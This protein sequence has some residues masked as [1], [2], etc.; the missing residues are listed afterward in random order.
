MNTSIMNTVRTDLYAR[1]AH[2]VGTDTI[3]SILETTHAE[4]ARTAIIDEFLPVL[5]ERDVAARLEELGA[6]ATRR[7]VFVHRGNRV[8]ADGAAAIAAKLSG[9]MVVATA[10]AAHPEN[11]TD[12]RMD[13]VFAERGYLLPGQPTF[14]R[15]ERTLDAA[16]VVVYL[17][18]HENQNVAA[19]RS[20][21]WNAPNTEGFSWD[22]A[23]E[24]ADD[25]EARVYGLLRALNVPITATGH[26]NVF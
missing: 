15:S 2:A 7:V 25:I 10:T 19:A 22:Q 3:D 24:V 16:D 5:V 18:P 23:R 4:H 11:E 26:A 14:G 8:L 17:T 6:K 20:L 12:E 9:G 1:Y 13:M 21:T